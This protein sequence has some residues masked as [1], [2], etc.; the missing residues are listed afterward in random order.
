MIVLESILTI[1]FEAAGAVLILARAL[2]QNTTTK[3]N[4]SKF[5]T[6]ST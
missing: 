3:L 6:H 5:V 2:N 1:V 4:L